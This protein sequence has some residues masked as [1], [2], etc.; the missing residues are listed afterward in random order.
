M[1]AQPRLGLLGSPRAVQGSSGP[2]T[3]GYLTRRPLTAQPQG[4]S[5]SKAGYTSTPTPGSRPSTADPL[6]AHLRTPVAAPGSAGRRSTV[7]TVPRVSAD[8][9]AA[10][11]H[12][13][14]TSS[15]L[16]LPEQD[17]PEDTLSAS[18]DSST[19][20]GSEQ[21]GVRHMWPEVW[22][23]AMEE[24]EEAAQ[25]HGAAVG[26]GST[27]P[28]ALPGALTSEHQQLQQDLE[29]ALASLP[30]A[31]LQPAY[32]D[33]P[34]SSSTPGTQKTC[35]ESLAN[36]LPGDAHLTH[37]YE[38]S[39]ASS[40]S[41]A[42]FTASGGES[43]CLGSD[44]SSAALGGPAAPRAAARSQDRP[45]SFLHGPSRLKKASHCGENVEG[46]Q[47]SESSTS[48][49]AQHESVVPEQAPLAQ[50]GAQ[51]APS[52]LAGPVLGL[53]RQSSGI[54]IALALA[55]QERRDSLGGSSIGESTISNSASAASTVVRHPHSR[56]GS[57]LRHVLQLC[58]ERTM[59]EA[60]EEEEASPS[61][62]KEQVAHDSFTIIEHKPTCSPIKVPHRPWEEAQ[63]QGQGQEQSTS[64]LDTAVQQ[65][66][67][68]SCDRPDSPTCSTPGTSTSQRMPVAASAEA[69]AVPQFLTSVSPRHSHSR[70]ASWP[71]PHGL[72]EDVAQQ[73]AMPFLMT[74]SMLVEPAAEASGSSGQAS[75]LTLKEPTLHNIPLTDLVG[76]PNEDWDTAEAESADG[77]DGKHTEDGI[78]GCPASRSTSKSSGKHL[79]A[80]KDS[81]EH[82]PADM[83][84]AVSFGWQLSMAA[85][86]SQH[87]HGLAASLARNPS[88]SRS[89]SS[90][91]AAAAAAANAMAQA[92][93]ALRILP[94]SG[95]EQSLD[96]LPSGEVPNPVG[97]AFPPLRAIALSRPPARCS[98]AGNAST[99]GG[100]ISARAGRLS[101][102]A[103]S[104][105]TSSTAAGNRTESPLNAS[106]ARSGTGT[107]SSQ[108]ALAAASNHSL[109]SL[110]LDED[111]SPSSTQGPQD[112]SAP[113]SAATQT[114]ELERHLGLAAAAALQEE[115]AAS[116]R[117][118]SSEAWLAQH[119]PPMHYFSRS[120]FEF[121]QP[122][123]VAAAASGTLSRQASGLQDLLQEPSDSDTDAARA[124]RTGIWSEPG[125]QTAESGD[126]QAQT[127]R[128]T[129]SSIQ[130][131]LTGLGQSGRS[132]AEAPAAG[133]SQAAALADAAPAECASSS[134][135][136]DGRRSQEEAG[137]ASAAVPLL[138]RT[139]H[140]ISRNSMANSRSASPS[141]CM[142]A[143]VSGWVHDAN[144]LPVS[145]GT[146]GRTSPALEA[147]LVSAAQAAGA[148]TPSRSPSPCFA[149]AGTSG[150]ASLA[151]PGPADEAGSSGQQPQQQQEAQGSASAGPLAPPAAVMEQWGSHGLADGMQVYQP[152]NLADS[153]RSKQ[154]SASTLEQQS[155]PSID[156]ASQ[157][158]ASDS[159]Q[160]AQ[161]GTW[162]TQQLEVAGRLA[163]YLT[164]PPPSAVGEAVAAA[165]A[166]ALVQE[167]EEAGE[168]PPSFKGT[169]T[170]APAPAAQ[171]LTPAPADAAAVA[172]APGD[173]ATSAPKQEA[174]SSTSSTAVFPRRTLSAMPSLHFMERLRSS[175]CESDDGST[176]YRSISPTHKLHAGALARAATNDDGPDQS[177][178][179][180]RRSRKPA[181]GSVGA[182]DNRQVL[183]APAVTPD[184]PQTSGSAAS[185]M[186]PL[187]TRPSGD[188]PQAFAALPAMPGAPPSTPRT[189][190]S[191][192]HAG[193]QR[194]SMTGGGLDLHG[195]PMA[196]S[197]RL[198]D[199]YNPAAG[200]IHGAVEE[201]P[202]AT[203][204]SRMSMVNAATSPFANAVFDRPCPFDASPRGRRLTDEE[205]VS[206]FGNQDIFMSTGSS[207]F[208]AAWN[209]VGMPLQGAP[210]AS[211]GGAADDAEEPATP[212]SRMSL[213]NA[214]PFSNAVYDRPCPFQLSPTGS[215]VTV[216]GA[217]GGFRGRR[218]E[219]RRER[220]HA[221]IL[222]EA[223][224]R[225]RSKR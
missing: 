47:S 45:S 186:R 110:V 31:L 144:S 53:G 178:N 148:K 176:P 204:T 96:I 193:S 107:A 66:A 77:E 163:G 80:H 17:G 106:S 127:V 156:L 125:N 133:P 64:S 216:D 69:A 28:Q 206:A 63:G 175:R 205:L 49:S 141:T 74:R 143:S 44:G 121:L 101:T 159:S 118:R 224:E 37:A 84:M 225:E 147:L 150:G 200:S 71:M 130:P 58:E 180:S 167:E 104:S 36:W 87:P 149:P 86:T 215:H 132:S 145:V 154:G 157:S 78:A 217:S 190:S 126:E 160:E 212:T 120:S 168:G 39:S 12:Q 184:R 209:A 158:H 21:A 169:V 142:R 210:Y 13:A 124:A 65:P 165:A 122:G 182:A 51:P 161:L 98:T 203:P 3:P 52:T 60:D 179:S 73:Q 197:G 19:G 164:L 103:V 8:L 94:P 198:S 135:P 16:L 140:D 29:D 131:S 199:G 67:G 151:Q 222:V 23:R 102:A 72:P 42:G 2:E 194:G 93:A 201:S 25:R 26:C 48:T 14:G 155:S 213:V 57:S 88:F 208:E 82:D 171:A 24:E 56:S 191:I 214:S 223:L 81:C 30:A 40:R 220:Q 195:S 79:L 15:P 4:S 7:H 177:P 92:P 50:A 75:G 181:V 35:R 196:T 105:A 68:S 170:E 185:A 11:E 136:A 38:S 20:S 33:S 153:A 90:A 111:G 95:S 91:T 173:A 32:H 54:A 188:G 117:G 139:S 123:S 89:S 134:K 211:M 112:M 221:A 116:S 207:A 128:R 83:P 152:T 85:A 189:R 97:P 219:G 55:D 99:G 174:S 183:L 109:A 172:A 10:G 41:L 166:A 6:L 218:A 1:H 137:P 18:H 202:P 146:S 22:S 34:A 59:S 5:S 43:P 119:L 162:L 70:A 61:T 108:G 76:G 100:Q 187:R 129:V 27:E 114:G 115:Q 46:L 138:T 192:G 113:E 9:A 62:P